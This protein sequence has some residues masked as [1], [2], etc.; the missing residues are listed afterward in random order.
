M[1]KFGKKITVVLLLCTAAFFL[2]DYFSKL[3]PV[4]V[5]GSSLP[6]ASPQ[7]YGDENTL[8]ENIQTDA[9]IAESQ[10]SSPGE[11][12]N[13]KTAYDMYCMRRTKH[14]NPEVVGFNDSRVPPRMDK[15]KPDD[16]KLLDVLRNIWIVPPSIEQYNFIDPSARELSSAFNQNFIIDDILRQMV[17]IYIKHF[18]SY[19]EFMGR[20]RRISAPNDNFYS[21][22]E[23]ERVRNGI[24]TSL[25]FRCWVINNDSRMKGW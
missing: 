16:Q 7:S 18:F 4:P 11:I 17:N 22:G 2:F 12:K 15:M 8:Q 24:C 5:M 19:A 10:N 21:L 9:T 13:W 6:H 3:R 1:I 25:Q 20:I 23:V 14:K